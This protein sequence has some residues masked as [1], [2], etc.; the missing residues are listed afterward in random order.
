[1]SNKKKDVNKG[2]EMYTTSKQPI[3]GILIFILML[4][5]SR[6]RND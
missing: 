5:V 1:M 4:I 3:D 6:I 2:N